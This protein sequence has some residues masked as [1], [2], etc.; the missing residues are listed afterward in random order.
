[1]EKSVT[2]DKKNTGDDV[3]AGAFA[4]FT[5]RLV[6]APLDV[7]KIRF[8]LQFG[9]AKKYTST[10]QAFRTIIA[11][12]GLLS[13]WKGNLSATYLWVTYSM[14]QFSTYEFLK[15]LGGSIPDPFHNSKMNEIK[16]NDE[17]HVSNKGIWKT[18]ILF[19]AGAGAGMASTATTYPLDIM[20]TQFAI[21]GKEKIHPNMR[22]FITHTMRTKGI[23]GFYAG[24]PAALVGITPYMG[25]N[26]AI[27]ETCNAALTKLQAAN[28]EDGSKYVGTVWKVIKSGLCGAVSGG[29]AKFLVF[30]LD[31]VKKRMQVQ[32]LQ[33][34]LHGAAMTPKYSSMSHCLIQTYRQEGIKGLFKG[35]VPTTLKSVV[36]T[37]VTFAAYEGAKEFL[38]FRR[39]RVV[40]PKEKP[41]KGLISRLDTVP[42]TP[43]RL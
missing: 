42:S 32:V 3:I 23:P 25:L 30:P 40:V 43:S 8:Q 28:N 24:L 27:Y 36:A 21:Q 37:A 6:T 20:R 9:D 7:L 19:L 31:T 39:N 12:E 13:L 29:V 26:F 10:M 4:G 16:T 1:M 11:E 5:A 35:I 14:V 18:F 2:S 41:W 34:T 33:S 17:N 22:S 15:K 38:K